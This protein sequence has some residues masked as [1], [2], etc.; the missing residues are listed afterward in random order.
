MSSLLLNEQEIINNVSQIDIHISQDYKLIESQINVVTFDIQET[1]SV[2][3][4]IQFSG[5]ET[6]LNIAR[7]DCTPPHKANDASCLK[8]SKA[9]PNEKGTNLSSN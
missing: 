5:P 4:S 1:S 3:S 9:V 7:I 6:F 8:V 2:S